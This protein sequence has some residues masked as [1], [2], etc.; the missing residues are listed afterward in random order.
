MP[1]SEGGRAGTNGMVVTKRNGFDNVAVTPMPQRNIKEKMCVHS[2]RPWCAPLGGFPYTA[3]SPLG[4]RIDPFS[5]C[6]PRLNEA[7]A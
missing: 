2:G 7:S 4:A 6:G 5:F 3:T 1:D